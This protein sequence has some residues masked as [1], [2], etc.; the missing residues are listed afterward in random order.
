MVAKQCDEHVASAYE[1]CVAEALPNTDNGFESKHAARRFRDGWRIQY[2]ICI[3]V[4]GCVGIE[5]VLGVC[6]R[7][8]V[9][10]NVCC[11]C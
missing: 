8:L 3:V 6:Y 2:I 5:Y 11:V 10:I 1:A 9:D 7:T 4:N